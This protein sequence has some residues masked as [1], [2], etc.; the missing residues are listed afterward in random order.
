MS[1]IAPC[2][3]D[4]RLVEAAFRLPAGSATFGRSVVDFERHIQIS[5]L[6][7]GLWTHRIGSPRGACAL[8]DPGEPGARRHSIAAPPPSASIPRCP[9]GSRRWASQA[10]GRRR[11]RIS[12]RSSSAWGFAACK[13]GRMPASAIASAGSS[14][15]TISRSTGGS[16]R[17]A[18]CGSRRG[19][20]MIPIIWWTIPRDSRPGALA[21]SCTRM[22]SGNA[23]GSRNG[24]AC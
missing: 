14:I 2:L 11:P 8:L 3:R 22:L 16:P 1:S 15:N 9:V 20:G 18:G 23:Q 21:W 6:Q 4:L 24:L 5:T 7:R 10:R 19:D 17:R 12:R 13:T